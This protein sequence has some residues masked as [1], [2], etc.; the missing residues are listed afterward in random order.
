MMNPTDIF[1][2]KGMWD[3]FTANHPKF[4]MWLNA[5][6]QGAIR[7]DS[8]IEINVKTPEGDNICTNLKITASDM[9]LFRTISSMGRQYISSSKDCF[10]K[11]VLKKT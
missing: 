11:K 9:E 3:Q 2:I 4:P 8:I 1:K 10:M 6:S 7:E 5:V